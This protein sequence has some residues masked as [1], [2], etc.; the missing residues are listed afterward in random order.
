MNSRMHDENYQANVASYN[1]ILTSS[2][3]EGNFHFSIDDVAYYSSIHKLTK[4]LELEA[5]VTDASKKFVTG[6]ATER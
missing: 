3:S 4:G 1:V 5:L 6:A 2:A